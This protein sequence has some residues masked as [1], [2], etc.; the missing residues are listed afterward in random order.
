M[1]YINSDLFEMVD[2]VKSKTYKQI[3]AM[4]DYHRKAGNDF[5]V[6]KIDTARKIVRYSKLELELDQ[7][8]QE[9]DNAIIQYTALEA[10]RSSI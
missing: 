1:D 9:K 8:R 5:V 4:R 2:E 3:Q 10:T 7:A 6:A